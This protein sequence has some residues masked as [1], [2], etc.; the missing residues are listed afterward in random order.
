MVSTATFRFSE[1]SYWLAWSAVGALQ[2]S[3]VRPLPQASSLLS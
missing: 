3:T 1:N 2:Y